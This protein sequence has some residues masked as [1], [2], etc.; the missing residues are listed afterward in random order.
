[1][2]KIGKVETYKKHTKKRKKHTEMFKNYA[3]TFEE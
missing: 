1:M 3:K 2:G